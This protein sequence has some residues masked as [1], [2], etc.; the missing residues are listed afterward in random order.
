MKV[1]LVLLSLAAVLAACSPRQQPAA[2]PS[3]GQTAESPATVEPAEPQRASETSQ[4][5]TGLY[6]I[7]DGRHE[8]LPCEAPDKVYWI[9][10][11]LPSLEQ[12][13]ADATLQ[14]YAGQHVYAEFTGALVEPEADRGAAKSSPY[15]AQF[16]VASV[17]RIRPKNPRNTCLPS[18]YWGQGNEPFWSLQISKAEGVIELSQL[19]A[20]T[21]AFP[22]AKPVL[23]E[24]GRITHYVTEGTEQRLKVAVY[25]EECLDDMAGNRFT[26]RMEVRFKGQVLRGCANGEK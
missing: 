18:D 25:Q 8:F 14:G 16:R 13:Y 7:A 6:R 21:V 22:Y 2:T 1:F 15:D 24:D 3:A 12:A 17:Q 19:G 11:D 5:I 9:L 4:T 23:E 26:H 20:P 10:G